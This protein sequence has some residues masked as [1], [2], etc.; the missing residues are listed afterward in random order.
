MCYNL[1]SGRYFVLWRPLRHG[2]VLVLRG[3]EEHVRTSGVR[4][5]HRVQPR[6][7]GCEARL[8]CGHVLR[9]G[10]EIVVFKSGIWECIPIRK[11]V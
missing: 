5:T 7:E 10:V 2:D 9:F 11:G 6:S 4:D 3:G 8:E 1:G